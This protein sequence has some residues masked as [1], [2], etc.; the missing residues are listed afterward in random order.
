MTETNCI[1]PKCFLL[2]PAQFVKCLYLFD[3]F[4]MPDENNGKKRTKNEVHTTHLYHH[5]FITI[6]FCCP[7]LLPQRT[8]STSLSVFRTWI[9]HWIIYMLSIHSVYICERYI[10]CMYI[11]TYWSLP[12]KHDADLNLIS[13]CT[14]SQLSYIIAK[15]RIIL[16]ANSIQFNL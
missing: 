16:Q 6:D 11:H 14:W 4:D 13:V 9:I 1:P 8:I 15:S 10:V 3:F 5:I 12:C 7:C 2:G